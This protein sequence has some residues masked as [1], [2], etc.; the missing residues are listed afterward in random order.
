MR[1][2]IIQKAEDDFEPQWLDEEGNKF[3]PKW[4]E[5]YL[6]DDLVPEYWTT[7]E[8]AQ[9]ACKKFQHKHELKNGKVVWEGTL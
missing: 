6:R 3:G 9:E 5:V 4:K 2:R 8:E 1:F 7:I